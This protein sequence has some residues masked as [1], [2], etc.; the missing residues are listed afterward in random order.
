MKNEQLDQM[1]E[2]IY[3]PYASARCAMHL[4]DALDLLI[5]AVMEYQDAHNPPP[6]CELDAAMGAASVANREYG[7]NETI[8]TEFH[9][10]GL[11]LI[12]YHQLRREDYFRHQQEQ[13]R[14][15][16]KK[17]KAKPKTKKKANAA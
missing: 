3:G 11:E 4:H 7:D 13:E 17:A 8:E 5:T 12:K 6:C 15:G 16:A 14:Q 2:T 1:F 9:K 10:R